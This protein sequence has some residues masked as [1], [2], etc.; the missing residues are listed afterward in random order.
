MATVTAA[1]PA[2]SA[3]R[4]YWQFPTFLLGLAAFLTAWQGWL[5]LG[6]RDPAA[7]FLADLTALRNINDERTLDRAELKALVGR[8]ASA[9]DAYPEHAPA[10]HFA[11][12]TGYV[13]LAELSPTPNEQHESWGLAKQHFD[14]VKPDQLADAADAPRLAYRAAKA[15]AATLGANASFAEINLTRSFL[16]SLPA[17]EFA[18]DGPRLIAELSLRF[19]PPDALT[20]KTMLT[21]YIS[22]ADLSTPPA[23]IAR[24]KLRLSEVHLLLGES[25]PA[26]KWLAQIGSDAPPD[27]LAPAKAQLARI[28]MSEGNWNGAAK[29]LE[30]VL[31]ANGVLPNLRSMAQYYL[32]ECRLRTSPPDPN[33]A[34]RYFEDAVKAEGPEGAASAVRLADLR[35]RTNDAVK[36]KEAASLLARSVKGLVGPNGYAN[37][38]VPLNEVQATFE[39]ALQV[40]Q[41]DGAYEAAVQVA[42]AYPPLAV[43]GRDREKRAELFANWGESLRK[44]NGEYKPKLAAA[45]ADYLALAELQPATEGKVE[46]LRRAAKLFR[47]AG[48]HASA[49]AALERVVIVPELPDAVG[50]AA[51]VE[52]AEVLIVCHPDRPEEVIRAFNKAMAS[53]SPVGITTRYRIARALLDTRD[54]RLSPLGLALMEQVAGQTAVGPAEAETHER[55]LVELAHEHIRAGKFQEAEARL[56]VQ[57]GRYPTGPEAGLGKLLRGICLLQ[58]ASA[59]AKPTDLDGPLAAQQRVDALKLFKEIVDDVEKREKPGLSPVSERDRWLWL[60]ASLRICQTQLQLGQPDEVLKAAAP[61][62][63]RYRGTV[64][65]LIALSLIYHAQKMQNRTELMPRTKDRMFEVFAQLKDKPGAFKATSGEYS[66]DYWEKVWFADMTPPVK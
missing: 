25:E 66:R 53:G 30:A 56:S 5:P 47:Q 20:A 15:R 46:L 23:S 41:A 59:K 60:Q 10:A 40:L 35:L 28:M 9:S 27:V 4:S 49:L 11:L 8:V 52:Y 16:L 65:E 64:E 34:A 26:R 32:G 1:P 19:V 7:A 63:E 43:P 38:L 12:G 36:H 17:G 45:A 21:Q 57:L 18:G 14:R 31:A 61:I 54:A 58:L 42:D 39:L 13:R 50:G 51:W 24:A 3:N 55:A 33:A 44:S 6:A 29:E 62:I 48:D 2:R 22:G 37:P